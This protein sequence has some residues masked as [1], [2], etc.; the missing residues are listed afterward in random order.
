MKDGSTSD[1]AA[2]APAA[3][4]VANQASADKTTIDVEAKQKS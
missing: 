3:G 4:Q 2:P 1:E